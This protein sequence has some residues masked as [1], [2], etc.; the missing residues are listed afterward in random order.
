MAK[1]LIVGAGGVGNVVV[2]KCAQV[3]EVFDE[4]VL[5][6]RTK[7]KCNAIAEKVSRPI[8]TEQVDADDVDQM[9][10]LIKKHKP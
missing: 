10:S 4:I 7:S 1:V 9:V 8:V 5:A 2:H 6:S 3:A